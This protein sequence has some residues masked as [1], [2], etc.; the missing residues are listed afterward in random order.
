MKNSKRSL[1]NRNSFLER[2]H[3]PDDLAD[4]LRRGMANWEDVVV[5]LLLLLL[6]LLLLKRMGE[7]SLRPKRLGRQLVRI[8]LRLS[9]RISLRE[10]SPIS[11]K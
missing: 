1:A 6:L 2:I 10:N 11:P 3:L 9:S 8:H 5:V 4:K 7:E